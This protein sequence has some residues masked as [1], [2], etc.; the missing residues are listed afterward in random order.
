MIDDL[1]AHL[2]SSTTSFKR[3]T[4]AQDQAP[5]D[6][7]T[8]ELPLLGVFP[9]AEHSEPD[10]TDYL[11]SKVVSTQVLVHIV[12]LIADMEPL[13]TELRTATLGWCPSEHHSDLTLL[14]GELLQLK[15]GICWW[16]ETYTSRIVIREAY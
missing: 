15:A 2:E 4:H 3:I 10:G 5:V 6:N 14:S 7:I 11:D 16:Q 13:R 12:C 9:G 8:E 1:I